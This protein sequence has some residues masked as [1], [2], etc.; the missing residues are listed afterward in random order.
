MP[1][2]Y[3]VMLKSISHVSRYDFT[4]DFRFDLIQAD[5]DT[6]VLMRIDVSN[7]DTVGGV[8]F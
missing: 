7:I 2:C 8:G 5:D 3:P 6:E 4:F 1:V